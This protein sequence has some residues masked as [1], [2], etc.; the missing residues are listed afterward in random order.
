MRVILPNAPS[1]E[2]ESCTTACT[3]F[4]A[5]V[6]EARATAEEIVEF[7]M[8]GKPAELW[9]TEETIPER[10]MVEWWTPSVELIAITTTQSLGCRIFISGYVK[11]MLTVGETVSKGPSSGEFNHGPKRSFWSL[12]MTGAAFSAVFHA[13]NPPTLTKD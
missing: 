4:S 13:T 9:T 2:R 1:Q 11:C 10:D 5:I 7:I 3:S 12:K 6:A 8:A